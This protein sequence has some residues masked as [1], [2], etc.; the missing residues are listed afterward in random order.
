MAEDNQNVL[1]SVLPKQ[2]G[3][4]SDPL[5]DPARE[6]I[7]RGRK[8]KVSVQGAPA[9]TGQNVDTATAE[10]L[11]AAKENL[12]ALYDPKG[13]YRVATFPLDVAQFVTGAKEF[14]PAKEEQ[15]AIGTDIGLTLR[16]WSGYDPKYLVLGRLGLNL[17]A[18]YMSH[19][20]MYKAR[21]VH[22]QLKH[23]GTPPAQP[24]VDAPRSVPFKEE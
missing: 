18:V 4:A 8:A 24:S 15:E 14:E 20:V 9:A 23:N 2:G 10:Q 5:G 1:D 7:K 21:L 6:R 19:F 17:F 12:E 22:D 13:W 11:A 3:T 16:F